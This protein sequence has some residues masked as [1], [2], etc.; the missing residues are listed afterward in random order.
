MT[1]GDMMTHKPDNECSRHNGQNASCGE[2]AP[3]KTR[4]RDRPCHDSYNGFGV[5][6]CKCSGSKDFHPGEHETDESCYANSGGDVGNGRSLL[7]L[8]VFIE[9]VVKRERRLGRG[10]TKG[11]S[12]FQVKFENVSLEHCGEWRYGAYSLS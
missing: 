1:F 12:C 11:A 10:F 2:Y 8:T 7:F 6:C 9:E 4:G 5:Y 3:V